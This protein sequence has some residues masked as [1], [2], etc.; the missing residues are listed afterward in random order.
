MKLILQKDIKN[1]G[2][3]G[4]Q[5]FV[6]KGYARNYL[7]PKKLALP[8]NTG[9]LKAWKHQNILIEAKKRK[10]LLERKNLIEK[11][12]SLNIEFEKESLKDGKLFGSVTAFE[13]SQTL[14]KKYNIPIDKKDISPLILKT[15]GDHT[16]T[17]SLDA[18]HKT[19]ITVKVKGKITKKEEEER[20]D[21][22]IK[23]EAV[24][25]IPEI[26]ELVLSET[27]L[28]KKEDSLEIETKDLSS[29]SLKSQKNMEEKTDKILESKKLSE[30]QNNSE[31]KTTS[32][33]YE[34]LENKNEKEEMKK[35]DTLSSMKKYLEQENTQKIKSSEES[36]KA[37]KI[38]EK[39]E[40]QEEKT[41]DQTKKRK[42]EKKKKFLFF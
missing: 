13:I 9:R 17:V 25:D 18:E 37:P 15:V 2:K 23:P 36:S 3:T 34:A 10:A 35:E 32:S 27:E 1:L 11:L 22:P 14:E 4:D 31:V 24:T 30:E 21:S 41:E 7:I 16:L 26:K 29:D 33:S 39:K 5:V 6:K 28:P 20:K 38:P 19:E 40:T 12:S 8:V 42:K